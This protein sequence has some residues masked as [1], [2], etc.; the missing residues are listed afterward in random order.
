[1]V[2]YNTTYS[3][4]TSL[5]KMTFG[6]FNETQNSGDYTS[7]KSSKSSFCSNRICLPRTSVKNQ[8]DYLLLKKANYQKYY[9]NTDNIRSIKNDLNSG[10]ITTIKLTDVAVIEN[11]IGESPTSIT[12]CSI[13]Y[14]DYTI[15]PLGSL[16]GNTVCGLNNIMDY[17]VYNTEDLIINKNHNLHP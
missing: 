9:K 16:F 11:V 1:M 14:L 4:A 13:P 3:G 8:G 2:N 10:L 7:N 15:D 5:G 12:V 6:Q 17:R